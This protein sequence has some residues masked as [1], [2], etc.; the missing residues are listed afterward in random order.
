MPHA[1][2]AH[3]F[4]LTKGWICVEIKQLHKSY[5]PCWE[6][7]PTHSDEIEVGS[8]SAWPTEQLITPG[9]SGTAK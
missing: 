1:E 7:Y 5:V 3:G 6:E 2:T 9:C 8:F 4:H